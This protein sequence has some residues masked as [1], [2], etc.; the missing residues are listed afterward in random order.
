MSTAH[1]TSHPCDR[2]A[3]VFLPVGVV[4]ASTGAFGAVW[5]QAE[6]RTVLA[7]AGARVIEGELGVGHAHECLDHDGA[8][9]L[10]ADQRGRLRALM[11]AL[12][13]EARPEAAA[14]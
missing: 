2:S 7:T 10:S 1:W 9:G 4:G 5:A 12:V 13:A 11:A 3:L 8:A 14:A 6:L